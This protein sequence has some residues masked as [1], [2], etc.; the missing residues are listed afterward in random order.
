MA[1]R[2]GNNLQKNQVRHKRQNVQSTQHILHRRQPRKFEQGENVLYV[3]T[4]TNT[5]VNFHNCYW[6]N[7]LLWAGILDLLLIKS[8]FK[9]DCN[10][11]SWF[12]LSFLFDSR[13]ILSAVTN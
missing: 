8:Y 9:D 10:I 6:I 13:H 1:D 11:I 12:H 4:K 3:S 7:R 2:E 5:K